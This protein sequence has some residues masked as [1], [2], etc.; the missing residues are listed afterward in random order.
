MAS[1][2]QYTFQVGVSKFNSSFEGGELIE[3][4]YAYQAKKISK[5]LPACVLKLQR[6]LTEYFAGDRNHFDIPY[7]LNGMTPFQQKVLK[8]A[9]RK[10]TFGKTVSY[11]R[12][13]SMFGKPLASRAVGSALGKNPILILV[14]CHRI[15]RSNGDL[16]GFS[17]GLPIKRKLLKLEG[18]VL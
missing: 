6:Q 15:L 11:Q 7:N 18:T 4:S 2:L 16:G 10:V 13:G 12:L 5:D 14:P 1:I 8:T 9:A 17:A 3:L